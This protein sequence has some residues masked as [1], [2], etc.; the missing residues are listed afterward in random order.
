ME[1]ICDKCNGTGNM[2]CFKPIELYQ[3]EK[4]M[5]MKSSDTYCICSK[6]KGKGKLN[7]IENILGVQ[8]LELVFP[9]NFLITEDL[10]F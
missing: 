3:F 8:K 4:N 9:K 1:Y 5:N 10:D 6:C 7:W 2:K